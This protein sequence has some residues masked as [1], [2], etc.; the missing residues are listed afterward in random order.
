MTPK[1]IAQI[2]RVVDGTRVGSIDLRTGDLA[3][4]AADLLSAWERLRKDG[5]PRFAGERIAG[6]STQGVEPL[7][8]NSLSYA[9]IALREQGFDWQVDG[10]RK[11]K[12]RH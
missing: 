9:L 3:T 12:G 2:V 10:T 6:D 11:R 8:G 1:L 4:D 7:S 5:A